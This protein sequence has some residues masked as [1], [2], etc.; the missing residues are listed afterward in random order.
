MSYNCRMYKNSGFNSSNIPDSP[1]ILELC[2]FQ[3]VPALE[4][5]QERFLDTIRVKAK[6]EDVKDVDYI[7]L[8]NASSTWFYSVESM[9]MQ[10]TDVCIFS[11]IPDYINSVGGIDKITIADGITDRVH[12]SND[13]FGMYTESDSLTTPAEPLEISKIWVQVSDETKTIV[14][15]TLDLPFQMVENKGTTFTDTNTET[16][17]EISVVVPTVVTNPAIDIIQTAYLLDGREERLTQGTKCFVVNST[18]KAEGATYD[19]SQTIRAGIN[20]LRSLGVE[21]SV[22][23]QVT[24]PT[25]YIDVN[26]TPTGALIGKGYTWGMVRTLT[27]KW[28]ENVIDIPYE[29]T[30]A[31]NNRVNYGEFTRYG[32]IS[33]SGESCEFEAEDI[34][35][36]GQT[37]PHITKVG[38]PRLTGKPYFRFKTV[39]GDSSIL[40]FFR[41]C[42]SG[43]PWRNVPL[44]FREVSGSALNTLKYENSKKLSTENYQYGTAQNELSKLKQ[45]RDTATKGIQNL[46]TLDVLGGMNTAMDY[47]VNSTDLYIQQMYRTNTARINRQNELSQI[48]IANTVTVPT[49]QFPYNAEFMRD[50]YGNGCL[51]YRY[52]YSQN[53]IN[54][55]DRLLT[56]Y[57]YKLSKPLEK[58]DFF[59]RQY[60]NF[61]MCTNVT[62]TGFN[63][64]INDGI[65]EQIANGV[66]V[67][68]TL[69]NTDY[70][71]NNPIK[72]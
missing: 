23:S 41:N 7:K 52:K 6:W 38:D 20:R 17:E 49:V 2:A 42:I 11:V 34:I 26:E 8:F 32:I 63:K 51:V 46:M 4:I 48:A 53:D 21:S 24:I 58:S 43:L 28:T 10:A 70:Y 12:V 67:W 62:V 68:H 27:G 16:G 9:S 50:F 13:G 18:Q 33:T 71:N 69:P 30:G 60:F 39:N 56:M 22:I 57:G 35:E 29:Y 5:L 19:L 15:S 31:K 66:R 36:T 65:R 1:Q 55:I 47:A 45:V 72:E 14:E 54:R 3:D 40:G 64:W 37:K 25:E 59:N 61:V 44:I